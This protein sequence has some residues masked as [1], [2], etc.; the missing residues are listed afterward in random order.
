M[1]VFDA[2]KCAAQT[3]NFLVDTTLGTRSL[4]D[5]LI[6]WKKRHY[7]CCVCS[8]VAWSCFYVAAVASIL[9]GGLGVWQGASKVGAVEQGVTVACVTIAGGY[10]I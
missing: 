6:E 8:G 9:P 4:Q 7:I 3:T 10:G 2:T 5:A 1:S